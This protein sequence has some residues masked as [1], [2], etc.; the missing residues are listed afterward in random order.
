MVHIIIYK[1]ARELTGQYMSCVLITGEQTC[2]LWDCAVMVHKIR[3]CCYGAQN[4]TV[5]LWCTKSSRYAL[6]S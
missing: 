4:Q 2:R 3:L 1:C 5:L 6:A